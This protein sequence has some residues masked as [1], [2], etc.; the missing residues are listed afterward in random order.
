MTMPMAP[1]RSGRAWMRRT[2]SSVT[3]VR[4]ES[5]MSMRRKL[6]MDL[7]CSVRLSGDRL[8]QRRVELEAHLG[9][10]DADVGVDVLRADLV[11]KLMVDVG[12]FLRLN[13]GTDAFAERIER[14]MDTLLIDGLG[15]THCVVDLHAGH[16]AGTHPRGRSGSSHKSRAWCDYVREQ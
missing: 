5:S 16:K 8:G 14:D 11:E 15:H 10:L 2:M 1:R 7:A 9:E 4:D 3:W 13:F 12:G 6:P